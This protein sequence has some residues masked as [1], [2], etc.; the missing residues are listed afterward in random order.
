MRNFL[1]DNASWIA[2][3]ALGLA[4]GAVTGLFERWRE[5]R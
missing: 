4:I 3:I 5:R 2:G 1:L